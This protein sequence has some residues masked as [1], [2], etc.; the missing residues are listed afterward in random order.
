MTGPLAARVPPALDLTPMRSKETTKRE[1]MLNHP[2]ANLWVF[3]ET[4][5]T[6]KYTFKT[7]EVI[8]MHFPIK[9]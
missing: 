2:F 1:E 4:D 7:L 6:K 5:D 3:E 9:R 8:E